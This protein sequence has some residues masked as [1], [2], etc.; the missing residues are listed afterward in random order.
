MVLQ[1]DLEDVAASHDDL[2]DAEEVYDRDE[3]IP[4]TEVFDDEFVG[5]HTA[6]ETF[7]D[8]V[9]ASPSDAASAAELDYV[10][11]GDWD[12]F[13]AEETEFDDEEAFVTAGRDHWVATRLGLV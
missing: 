7:D 9:A 8:L 2:P 11:D 5:E 6:F 12:E 4:L 1:G 10:A 3:P 13:V